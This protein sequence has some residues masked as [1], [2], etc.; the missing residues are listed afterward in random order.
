MPTYEYE[1]RECDKRCE[2][3]QGIKEG[4]KRK[5][6]ACGKLKLKRIISG[7][8]GLIFKGEGFYVNDYPKDKK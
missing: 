3:F 4:A 7:R 1:C 6:P 2:F 5:C 8:V